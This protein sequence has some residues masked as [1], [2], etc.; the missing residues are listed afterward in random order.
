[1]NSS[2]SLGQFGRAGAWLWPTS[3]RFGCFSTAG[4]LGWSI[5]CSHCPGPESSS[6]RVR[7]LT[8]RSTG[9]RLRWLPFSLNLLLSRLRSSPRC[10]RVRLA[11]IVRPTSIR[12]GYHSYRSALPGFPSRFLVFLAQWA[13]LTP[14]AFAVLRSFPLQ[15]QRVQFSGAQAPTSAP[16]QWLLSIGLGSTSS[17]CR[18]NLAL[19]SDP[20]GTIC[21]ALSG[22]GFLVSAHRPVA[23]R[24]G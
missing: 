22:S 10:R 4:T 7:G 17:R 15:A 21:R 8:S 13:R 11:T 16:G 23:G 3:S 6:I 14:S 1:M 2:V 18:P 20:T 19:N 5:S 12:L 9:P 24:A